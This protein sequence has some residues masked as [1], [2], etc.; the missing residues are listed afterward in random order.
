[1][2]PYHWKGCLINIT[3]AASDLM[4]I[5]HTIF[6][7]EDVRISSSFNVMRAIMDSNDRY[8]LEL[9]YKN[10]SLYLDRASDQ[11]IGYCE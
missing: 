4:S 2:Y 3:D 1:M 8:G 7:N 5:L 11:Y 9:C 10:E 6:F